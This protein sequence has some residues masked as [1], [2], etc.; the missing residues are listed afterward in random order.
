MPDTEYRRL[1]QAAKDK[2]LFGFLAVVQRAIQD[3][4]RNVVTLLS[5]A[6]SG[7]DHSALTAVRHFLRQD[8]NVF[9]RRADGLYRTY[10]ER[11]MQTM[12]TDLRPGMRR[13]SADELSLI[14][15]EAVN[16]QIEVGR[17]AQRMREA[18]EELVG[19]L[20]VIVA[21]LHGQVEA[22]EREN[23]FRPYLLARVVYE[24]IRETAADEAKEKMLYEHL[25]TAL[26]PH[27]SGF[28]SA[29]QDV[30][31]ASGVR[32]KFIAQRSRA[33]HHQRYFGAPLA[34]GSFG[35]AGAV[36]AAT[37]ALTNNVMP[38]L[39]R[40]FE[41]LQ[42]TPEAAADQD[43]PQSVQDF[44]RSMF[45]PGRKPGALPGPQA[46]AGTSAL[47][48]QLA[49]YQKKAARGEPVDPTL[50]PGKNQLAA[51]RERLDLDQASVMER[52]TVEV[53]TM[54][55]EIILEDEQI[56]AA[57]RNHIARLQIPTLKAAL[58]EPVLM[59]DDTHPAR[60]LLNRMSSAAI[61]TD[62]D[63]PAGHKLGAEMERVVRKVLDGF[64]TDSAVFSNALYEFETFLGDYLRED[65]RA[66]ATAIEAV[67]SAEKYSVL[68]TNSTRTL[69]DV[70][71]P[72]NVDKRI[73]D[74]II[75]VWPHVLVKAA[76]QDAQKGG[77]LLEQCQAVLPELVWSIQDKASAQERSVLIKLLPDLV[78]RLRAAMQ[79][80]QLPDDESKPML[81]LLVAMHTQILRGANRP[82]ADLPSLES[83]RQEFARVA[84][85][86]GRASWGLSE[87][88]QVRDAVIED[89]FARAGV[90]V[91]QNLIGSTGATAADREFLAQTYL[92][93]TR[94]ELRNG[95]QGRPAQ[96]VWISTHRSLYLFRA[97]DGRLIMYSAAALLEALGAQDIVP[98]EYAPVFERAVESLLFGA[99]KLTESV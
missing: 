52:M 58:L 6:K 48:G 51:L 30:F 40:M 59:H 56:P 46:P 1:I 11:A 74:F 55:F 25:A 75:T 61:G 80:I 65:D 20:N 85:S 29:I 9:L 72:L 86:W 16:Q 92:L 71:L 54:L 5:E 34:E 4:D 8:G 91:E 83:L 22:K 67:E 31:E 45:S 10:L 68:L 90:Q 64:E 26:I 37:V 73:S 76:W 7:L 81:D 39:N 44:I 78:R 35:A 13:L 62:P 53:V 38:G 50:E 18:N 98:L 36:S 93:G 19:R 69:C 70:L 41:T 15:D 28:F 77:K 99:E 12:Y 60:R 84:I 14:D 88:P 63:S 21:N 42:Q 97:D 17:L 95:G 3:A 43:Q 47:V 33:A 27:L 87:P 79:L 57:L 94:V 96:L 89:V 24:A 23:P 32:G 49:D 66:T 82:A 2:A